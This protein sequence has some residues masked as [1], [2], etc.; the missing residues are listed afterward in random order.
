MNMNIDAKKT[1]F[2]PY[3]KW[4]GIPPEEQPPTH[5]RLL[6]LQVF[7]SDPEV[8]LGAVMQRSAHLKTYQLGPNGPLTQKLLNEVSAAKVCLLDP[9]RKAAY[10]A[11]LRKEL[12][13]RKT[14][15]RFQ[16][17]PTASPLLAPS[18]PPADPASAEPTAPAVD[19]GVAEL[20]TEIEHSARRS[21]PKAKRKNSPR[22]LAGEPGQ[23]V[24]VRGAM[25]P[26]SHLW[27]R[28]QA[29][30]PPRFRTRDWLVAAGGAALAGVLLLGV[31]F[32][33]R[34]PDG[35]LVVEIIPP[36]TIQVLDD[37]GKLL[38]EQK[39]GAE[40]VEISVVPGKGKL[41]V[42]KNG[43][44]LITRGFSLVSGGRE[45]INARLDS[46]VG[47]GTSSADLLLDR[48]EKQGYCFCWETS[49][50][51]RSGKVTQ[52]RLDGPTIRIAYDYDD[53][54]ITAMMQGPK[55]VGSWKQS[56]SDGPLELTFESDFSRASGW[57]SDAER[58]NNRLDAFFEPASPPLGDTGVDSGGRP[59]Q[60]TL[61]PVKK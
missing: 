25:G 26:L 5:Y 21:G 37:Q 4:L 24:R 23:G 30:I 19:P 59:K 8:I 29:A 14:A 7:E 34:T 45:T 20:F 31:V 50:G 17:L 6:G 1:D 46:P 55:L 36:A 56:R 38:F 33:M 10:D 18:T 51:R 54:Q 28:C 52:V 27:Q 3:H 43:V 41:R 42:V 9:E 60:F 47:S 53:G 58:R 61:G 49:G 13:S 44:E 35:T 22:P 16:S 57:W 15:S 2:D 12:E 11:R 32:T 40:K 48:F 39:A